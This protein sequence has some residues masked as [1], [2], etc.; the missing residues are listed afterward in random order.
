MSLRHTMS[1]PGFEYHG[2]RAVAVQTEDFELTEQY[3]Q[4]RAEEE[5]KI[6]SETLKRMLAFIL[7]GKIPIKL[8]ILA[9]LAGMWE[10]H[11]TV[12]DIRRIYG[13]SKQNYQQIEKRALQMLG[14]IGKFRC[15][16]TDEGKR[17]MR[18][19]NYRKFRA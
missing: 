17:T 1:N 15:Q 19:S 6:Q 11:Y 10:D 3:V 2:A 13:I 12:K 5:H 9:K 14:E 4:L 16:R 8:A 18:K 7:P